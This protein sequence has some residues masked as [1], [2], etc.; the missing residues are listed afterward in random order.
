[1]S[2][3]IRAKEFYAG[4]LGLEII[5]EDDFALVM[6]LGITSLRISEVDDFRAQEF[7]VLGWEVADIVSAAKKLSSLDITPKHYDKLEHPRRQ[8]SCFLNPESFGGSFGAIKCHV[9]R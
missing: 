6:D 2:N 4:K 5:Y 9:I 3:R 8:H 7:T 1:M